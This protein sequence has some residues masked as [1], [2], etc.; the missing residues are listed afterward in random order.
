MVLDDPHAA[1]DAFQATFLILARQASS[2]RDR[3]SVASWLHRIAWRIAAHARAAAARRREIERQCARQA[4]QLSSDPER[5]I[6]DAILHD[7]LIRL[8]EKYRKPIVL[9]YLEGLTHEGAAEQLGW[10]VGT[11]RGRLARAR[12]LLRARLTRRGVT[13]PAV[14]ARRA[15]SR[16]QVRPKRQSQPL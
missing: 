8:P 12:D 9:C 2:I 13:S 6:L 11:V 15:G 5:I 16:R 4:A 7:E 10:P 1:E 3:G 14:V